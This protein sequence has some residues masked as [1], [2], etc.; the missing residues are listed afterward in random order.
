M[1]G[2]R[3][4]RARFLELRSWGYVAKLFQKLS[5]AA[6]CVFLRW[7]EQAFKEGPDP[8]GLAR[9]VERGSYGA[10]RLTDSQK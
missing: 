1:V 3:G 6:Q 8:D 2:Q 10:L 5:K 4:D 9:C 7:D